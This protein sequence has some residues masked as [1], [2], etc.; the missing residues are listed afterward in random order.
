MAQKIVINQ[1][2]G[3]FGLSKQGEELYQTY[4][5]TPFSHNVKRNDPHLIQVVEELKRKSWGMSSELYIIEIPDDCTEWE[6]HDY[7]GM[8][9][10]HEKHRY[11]S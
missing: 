2:W 1:C 11:W 9:S 3:G 4:S 6:I 5:N 7:D 10:V 8:E